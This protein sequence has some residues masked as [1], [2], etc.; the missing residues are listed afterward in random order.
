MYVL[1]GG[2]LGICQDIV[3]QFVVIVL[4]VGFDVKVVL[5]DMIVDVLL[6]QGVLIVVVV[7]YNGCVLDSVCML[8]V[9]LDV[10]DVFMWQ[11]IGL[12]YV[13]FGCGNL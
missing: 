8:E 4:C 12:C 5:L 3:E 1:Y 2:S 13:V 6:Q 10:V 7:I 11:V 9:C